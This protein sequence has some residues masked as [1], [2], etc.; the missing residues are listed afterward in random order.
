RQH[1]ARTIEVIRSIADRTYGIAFADDMP[2][3]ER[4]LWP[5]MDAERHGMEDARF[6]RFTNDDGTVTNFATYTAYDGTN[7][8]QQLLQTA[9][10]TPFTSSPIVAAAA[11]NRGL[12]LFPRRIAARFAALSRW[13]REANSIAFSDNPRHWPS[14]TPCQEP[15]RAW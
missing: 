12:A 10:L 2:M 1:A 3:A 11:A 9:D 7:I 6:V 4:V 8:V 14:A 15:S 13:N 5:S